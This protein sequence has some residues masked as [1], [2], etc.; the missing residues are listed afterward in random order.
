LL[1]FLAPLPFL[2]PRAFLAALSDWHGAA[3]SPVG[4][5]GRAGEQRLVDEVAAQGGVVVVHGL[6]D[7]VDG[8]LRVAAARLEGPGGPENLRN[9][10]EQDLRAARL[11]GITEIRPSRT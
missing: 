7:L 2:A 4:A 1:V 3:R 11:A 6:Q 10:V 9:L 5:V 8:L